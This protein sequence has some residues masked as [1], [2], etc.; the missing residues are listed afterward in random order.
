VTWVKLDDRY[1][2]HPKILA[3]G[4]LAMALDIAGMCYAAGHETDGHIPQVTLPLLAPFLSPARQRDAAAKLVEVGRWEPVDDG[5]RIHDFLDYNPTASRVAEIR[6]ARQEAGQRG[7]KAS[8]KQRRSKPKANASA[9]ASSKP[10]ANA[11]GDAEAKLNPGPNPKTTPQ[12][13]GG[14]EGLP[15]ELQQAPPAGRGATA[16]AIATAPA[17]TSQ[18]LLAEHIDACHKRPPGQ[19]VGHLAR[20][21]KTLLDEGIPPDAIRTGLA[22]VRE[23]GLHPSTLPSAANEAM[24]PPNR[25]GKRTT[26]ALG[27]YQAMLNNPP[28]EA[29]SNGDGVGAV[30][31]DR[32]PAQR[33]LA[34]P[35]D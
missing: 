2:H 18:T 20:G 19:V 11:K 31:G 32:R 10:Q 24:N 34:R 28:E 4:P 33:E 9:S 23:R 35:A 30:G 16:L 5:W 6:S 1:A 17:P 29:T 21:I 25:L 27:T 12:T 15:V 7:G 14:T 8:G 3:A 26:Q 22:I 13:T